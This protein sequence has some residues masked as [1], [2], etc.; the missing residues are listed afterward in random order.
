M[1]HP[2]FTLIVM[3]VDPDDDHVLLSPSEDTLRDLVQAR[4]RGTY[5][6]PIV[7]LFDP[8]GQPTAYLGHHDEDWVEFGDTRDGHTPPD[9]DALQAISPARRPH[10]A[11]QEHRP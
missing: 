11:L 7:F 10:T 4:Y 8:Q 1:R 5:R 9:L 3:D 2:C 6:R